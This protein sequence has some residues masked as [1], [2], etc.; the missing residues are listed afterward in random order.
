M[1]FQ[2]RNSNEE[3]PDSA[4][5]LLMKSWKYTAHSQIVHDYESTQAYEDMAQAQFA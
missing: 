4:F 1:L 5:D 2:A 3:L